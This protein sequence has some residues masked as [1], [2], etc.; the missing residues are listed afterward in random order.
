MGKRRT[1]AEKTIK[2][3]KIHEGRAINFRVDTVMLPNG[4]TTTREVVEHPGSVVIIPM[5]DSEKV[6][7]IKQFRYATGETL[8]ELPA[9]TLER[10]EHLDE[11]AARELEEEAGYR[12]GKL[13]RVLSFYTAPGYSGEL[14]HAYLATDLT[15]VEQRAEE[16]EFIQVSAVTLSSALRM[17]DSGEIR[18]GKTICG[19]L[20]VLTSGRTG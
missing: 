13:E 4:K 18:D 14:I 9:G 8:L 10:G 3:N 19:I 7:L 15:P 5:L 17:V 1:L 11:C 16:D 6:V 2:S 20:Y 12:A